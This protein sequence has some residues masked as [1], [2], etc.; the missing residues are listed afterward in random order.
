M[1]HGQR[2]FRVLFRPVVRA[3]AMRAILGR[4]RVRGEMAKGRFTRAEIHALL[5]DTWTRFE[6]HA[7]EIPHER[8]AGARLWLLNGALIISA[9]QIHHQLDQH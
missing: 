8:S 6:K 1:T 7:A 4:N 9:I 2:L 3:A 5:T